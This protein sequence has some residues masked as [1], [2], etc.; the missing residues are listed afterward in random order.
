MLVSSCFK[1]W[2][3]PSAVNITFGFGGGFGLVLGFS[4]IDLVIMGSISSDMS[5]D[6]ARLGESVIV[7]SDS[8]PEM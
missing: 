8:A 2:I 7:E 6:V 5:S 1:R 3:F 4:F